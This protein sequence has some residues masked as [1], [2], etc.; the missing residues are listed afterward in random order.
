M[1]LAICVRAYVDSDNSFLRYFMVS[2]GSALEDKVSDF[3]LLS[4]QKLIDYL[5]PLSLMQFNAHPFS[6][7][8]ISNAK[9]LDQITQDFESL[10]VNYQAKLLTILSS[11]V[12][13]PE[14]A[15]KYYTVY[16]SLINSLQESIKSIPSNGTEYTN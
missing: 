11:L 3:E 10:A 9:I 5:F 14:I 1:E 16:N 12:S 6:W 4:D 2:I 15:S 7:L 13:S 8:I